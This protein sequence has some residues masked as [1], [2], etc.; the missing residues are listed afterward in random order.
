MKINE[1]VVNFHNFR[2][3]MGCSL[4]V[5]PLGVTYFK[6]VRLFVGI[7]PSRTIDSLSIQLLVSVMTL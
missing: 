6:E 5:C 2:I 3:V 4:Q 7:D 1:E